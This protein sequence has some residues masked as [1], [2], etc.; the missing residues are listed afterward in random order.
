MGKIAPQQFK[1]IISRIKKPWYDN[2]LKHQMQ[3]VINR[4]RKWLKYREQSHWKAYKRE[5]NRFITMIK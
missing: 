5:R 1:K 4:E 3:I 2:D